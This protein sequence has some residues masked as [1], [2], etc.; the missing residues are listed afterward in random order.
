MSGPTAI[1]LPL[2]PADILARIEAVDGVGSG[3][4]ADL[5]RGAGPTGVPAISGGTG[6]V[7]LYGQ[8]F[9]PQRPSPYP[10]SLFRI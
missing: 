2:S 4:D 9:A 8:V 3:L 7:P 1:T 10:A 5:I 6:G